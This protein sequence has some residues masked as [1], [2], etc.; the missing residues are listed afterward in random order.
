MYVFVFIWFGDDKYVV[1]LWYWQCG[2]GCLKV[3][4]GSGVG[5]GFYLVVCCLFQDVGILG[6]VEV[7][8]FVDQQGGGVVYLVLEFLCFGVVGQQGGQ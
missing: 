2:E 5:K 1:D 3:F 6:E 7:V 4:Q 8:V